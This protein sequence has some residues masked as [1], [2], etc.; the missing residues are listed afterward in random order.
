MAAPDGHLAT[1]GGRLSGHLCHVCQVTSVR[2]QLRAITVR[3]LLWK[4]T[5][6]TATEH[7]QIT[8]V[9]QLHRAV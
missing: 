4:I 7:C 8:V 1:H 9:C 3:S 2:L 5:A 6:F